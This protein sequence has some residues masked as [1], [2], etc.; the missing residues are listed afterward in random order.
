MPPLP[1]PQPS[2]RHG[3]ACKV[4]ISSTLE[5]R[6]LGGCFYV[7]FARELNPIRNGDSS[8]PLWLYLT[9]DRAVKSGDANHP[10]IKDLRR[11]L[12][13]VV[14]RLIA[15]QEPRVAI[16]L[17]RE[18]RRAPI[19]MYRP[20]LWKIDL[21]RIAPG[22]IRTNGGNPAWDEQHI[23]DLEPGEFEVIVE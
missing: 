21:S 7:W 23:D 20:Q 12:L 5:Q 17:R 9:I 11:I 10:K 22:R 14:N 3:Y 15:R 13:G 2:G 1:K 19:E 4:W 16:A 18:I 6:H 8:N